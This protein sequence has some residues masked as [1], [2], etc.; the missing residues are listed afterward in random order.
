M[1]RI[2][3]KISGEALKNENKLVDDSKLDI[4]LETI[5]IL[6]RYNHKVAIVIGGGNIF[7]GRENTQMEVITRDTIGML[8]TVINALY[9]KDYLVKNNFDVIV[10]TPFKFPNLLDEYDDEELKK[11]YNK[12]NIIVF[13]GGVGKSGYSTDSGVILGV[14]KLDC[15]F[16]I[17][18]T[19]VDGV[20]DK[21]PKINE[22]AFKFDKLTYK[23]VIDNKYGVMD[24]FAIKI[25]MEKQIKILVMNFLE[26]KKLDDYFNGEKLG[27]EV[28]Y[29]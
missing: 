16:I 1:S 12:N 20:Y 13:G 2:I 5:K 17:K 7:R 22:D 6:K 29:D 25:A 27:T 3:L 8:G 26:Y 9:I 14:Q 15:D 21:D 11:Y 18:M 28:Y 24:E 4:I 10:A 23:E 19:N